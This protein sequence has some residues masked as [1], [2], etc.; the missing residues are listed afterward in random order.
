MEEL[1]NDM[2]SVLAVYRAVAC[3][4]AFPRFR[5]VVAIDCVDWGGAFFCYETEGLIA[6]ARE[7]YAIGDDT[8]YG[9]VWTCETCGSVFQQAWQDFS[10]HIS[11]STLK[12]V[13]LL[14]ADLGAAA[15]T[16]M[17]L[18]RGFAGHSH[19]PASLAVQVSPEEI[20]TWLTAR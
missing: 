3:P 17:R 5:Q 16:P 11:R 12:P 14:V 1:L 10:I 8:G 2:R 15:E 9:S 6:V 7:G 19:P 4:C 13:Q 20:K 18:S